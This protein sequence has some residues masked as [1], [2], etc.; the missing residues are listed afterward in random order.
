M[1]MSTLKELF[2]GHGFQI[3]EE[4]DLNIIN[5]ENPEWCLGKDMAGIIAKK[6]S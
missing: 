1:E 2:Q 6:L 3:M 4:F 5:E